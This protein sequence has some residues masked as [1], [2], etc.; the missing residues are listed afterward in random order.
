V[1]NTSMKSLSSWTAAC[2][3]A[4]NAYSVSC[5]RIPLGVKPGGQARL[6][7]ALPADAAGERFRVDGTR[8]RDLRDLRF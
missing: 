2:P 6:G 8:L 7:V 4:S 3:G 5:A 1:I